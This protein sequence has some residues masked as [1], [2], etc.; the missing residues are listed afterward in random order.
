MGIFSPKAAS[1][2]TVE[3][4][5]SPDSDREASPPNYSTANNAD[6]T[7]VDPMAGKHEGGVNYKSMTW[8]YVLR[9]FVI[10]SHSPFV[11]KA[12]C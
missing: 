9:P 7:E 4:P 2:A 10:L 8:W 12:A 5:H 1:A 6:T 3:K 11:G